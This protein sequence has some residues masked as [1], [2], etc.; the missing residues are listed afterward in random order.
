MIA[1]WIWEEGVNAGNEKLLHA[2]GGEKTIFA[3]RKWLR[4]EINARRICYQCVQHQADETVAVMTITIIHESNSL[5][6]HVA[7]PHNAVM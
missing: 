4:E 6:G 1:T 7:I 5:V 3:S 2:K